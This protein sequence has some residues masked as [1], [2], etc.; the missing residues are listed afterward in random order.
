MLSALFS[1]RGMVC[2]LKWMPSSGCPAYA[3]QCS[4]HVL[5]SPAAMMRG[6]CLRDSKVPP[7]SCSQENGNTNQHHLLWVSS[8]TLR[9]FCRLCALPCEAVGRRILSVTY[10]C[11]IPCQD[12]QGSKQVAHNNTRA[13]FCVC[14]HSGECPLA[15]WPRLMTAT[16]ATNMAASVQKQW[17]L[18]PTRSLVRHS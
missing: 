16:D 3:L 10:C 18:H 2:L 4:A 14:C 11:P 8:L 6:S 12:C 15:F 17:R 1:V 13:E 5:H 7:C 9:C